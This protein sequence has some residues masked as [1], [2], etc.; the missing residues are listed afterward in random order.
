MTVRL[1]LALALA[2]WAL[3]G[4]GEAQGVD[5]TPHPEVTAAD[6][7]V[8]LVGEEQANLVLY[9]SNQSFD[10]E[11][12]HLTVALDGVT[13]STATST[14]RASTTGSASL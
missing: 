6:A 2:S 10:D 9:A 11:E 7:A 1:P 14:S 12:V 13:W 3:V 4:C 8:R 5:P